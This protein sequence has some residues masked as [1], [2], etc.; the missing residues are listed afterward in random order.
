M[1]MRDQLIKNGV[2]NLKEFGYKYA[3]INNIMT[4]EVYK[5]FFKSMLKDSRAEVINNERLVSVI[6][7][8]L[9]EFVTVKRSDFVE[10]KSWSV[11][12]PVCGD[13]L[14]VPE[15]SAGCVDCATCDE[16]INVDE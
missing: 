4:D 5:E 7:N 9:K 2:N 3:T 8:L 12:C 16:W 13:K 6:D 14:N 10:I 15:Y 1:N 11:K